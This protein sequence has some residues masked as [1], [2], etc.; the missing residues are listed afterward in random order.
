MVES[1]L[2]RKA[3][4][5]LMFRDQSQSRI[6]SLDERLLR[7]L[8]T[9][10]ASGHVLTKRLRGAEH[11]AIPYAARATYLE[12]HRLEREGVLTSDWRP[13]PGRELKAKYTVSRRLDYADLT[14]RPPP[15][16]SA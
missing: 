8:S 12:L 11:H 10:P 9:A 1:L 5:P 15:C 14:H 2:P 7:I 3:L 6:S 4:R 16:R 13:V